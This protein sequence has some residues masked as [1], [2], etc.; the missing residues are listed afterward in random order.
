MG[1]L[2][3]YEWTDKMFSDKILHLLRFED[4][5]MFSI[6]R[7]PTLLDTEPYKWRLSYLKVIVKRLKCRVIIAQAESF[8]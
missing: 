8:D 4:E 3:I 2:K 5:G 6:E 1:L 7:R